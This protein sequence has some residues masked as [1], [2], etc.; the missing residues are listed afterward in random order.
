[1]SP[2]VEAIELPEAWQSASIHFA[3]QVLEVTGPLAGHVA[4]IGIILRDGTNVIVL[5]DGASRR[6]MRLG[7]PTDWKLEERFEGPPPP[8]AHQDAIAK[9]W[10]VLTECMIAG[11]NA[12]SAEL[13]GP[14]S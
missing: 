9:T 4:A 1:M 6:W 8:R 12:A 11:R 2:R 14:P 10:R 13:G 3:S 5:V 7:P